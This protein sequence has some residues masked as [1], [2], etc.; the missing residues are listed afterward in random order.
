MPKIFLVRLA[1]PLY[2]CSRIYFTLNP[3]TT[4]DYLNS[5]VWEG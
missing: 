2:F 1:Y 5:E 3:L 4:G